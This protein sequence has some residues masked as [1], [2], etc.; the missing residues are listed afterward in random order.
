MIGAYLC[1]KWSTVNQ[2]ELVDFEP[3]PVGGWWFFHDACELSG[4]MALIRKATV[5]AN[6]GKSLGSLNNLMAC[7]LNLQV[8]D[9]FL[10]RHIETSFELTLE[11]A[12][13]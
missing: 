13:G 8:A 10:G 6:L 4:K 3:S 5:V 12:K 11:R 2:E 1:I 9:V 7:V